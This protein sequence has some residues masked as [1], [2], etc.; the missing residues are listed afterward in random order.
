MKYHDQRLT[1]DSEILSSFRSIKTSPRL[2]DESFIFPPLCSENREMHRKS[3]IP[4]KKKI[5]SEPNDRNC[6]K[7]LYRQDLRNQ[8]TNLMVSSQSAKFARN[9]I[10]YFEHCTCTQKMET[11]DN[12]RVCERNHCQNRRREARHECKRCGKKCNYIPVKYASNSNDKFSEISALSYI[13]KFRDKN[14]HEQSRIILKPKDIKS[15]SVSRKEREFSER[16]TN[17]SYCSD[18]SCER[19]RVFVT[20]PKAYENS[21]NDLDYLDFKLK[22][23]RYVELCK[24]VKQSLLRTLQPVDVCKANIASMSCSD[25]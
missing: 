7:K 20:L 13:W 10:K 24:S 3:Q 5:E 12:K 1:D 18:D 22:L 16:D 19:K 17:I 9:D 23:L 8:A 11:C 6:N 4:R 25:T 15:F 2:H 21:I 14:I